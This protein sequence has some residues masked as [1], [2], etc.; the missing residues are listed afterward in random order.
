[1]QYP[2]GNLVA[3]DLEVNPNYFLAGFL[4]PDGT[5]Y[6]YAFTDTDMSQLEELHKFINWVEQSEFNLVGFN[7][8]GYDDPVL[9][10]FLARPC[11]TTPY[12]TSVRIIE[13]GE[14]FWNFAEDIKSID[15][16]NNMPKKSSLKLA[17]VRMGHKK[18]QEL[19]IDPHADVTLDEQ[20]IMKKY[21]Y[22][23]LL[24]TARLA[25]ELT[26]ELELRSEL[27]QTYGIDLRSKTRAQIAEQVLSHVMKESTGLWKNNLKDT[28]RKN[29]MQNPAF[30]IKV[31]NWWSNL[32]VEKYP[33]IQDVVDKATK[34]FAKTIYVNNFKIEENAMSDT[35]FVGDRWYK[36]GV[37]GLHSVD[38]PGCWLPEDDE[39]MEDIDVTSYYPSMILTQGLS[40]RHW[41]IKGFD[42]FKNTYGTILDQRVAAKRK[43]TEVESEI[44][45]L[46]KQLL[47]LPK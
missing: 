5:L 33:T 11:I 13:G 29:V 2:I 44:K 37:G 27:S 4:L 25:A 6:Q 7:S 15:I 43:L 21:N 28:A 14:P 39:D 19:P 32:P 22:N 9:S 16:M 10:E 46:E 8:S 17:G 47:S 45:E 12:E 18:L 36:M 24:I 35:I 31:P 26:E 1:M 42:H 23:D 3:Y 20:E 41:K 30:N 40:P 38:G 34:I